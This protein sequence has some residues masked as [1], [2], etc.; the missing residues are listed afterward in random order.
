MQVAMSQSN[1][2]KSSQKL[3]RI[4]YCDALPSNYHISF[5]PK[6]TLSSSISF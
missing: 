6:Y 5:G 3:L 4:D 2:Y 1:L